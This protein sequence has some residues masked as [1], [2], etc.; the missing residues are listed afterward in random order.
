[1]R[2]LL[3]RLSQ[4]RVIDLAQ[5]WHVGMPHWPSHPPFLYSLTKLHGETVLEGGASSAADAI[6]LGTHTGTHI[7]ALCHFSCL[8]KL[9]GGDEAARVQSYAGGLQRHSVDTIA[10][11]L[12]RGVL[13]DIPGFMGVEVL[14]QDFE[15]TAQHLE[16]AS[17]AQNVEVRAGDV[18]LLR[19]GWARHYGDPTLFLN[20]LVLPGPA[21]EGAR[22]LSSRGVFAVGSDTVAFERT[23][24]AKM[25][26]HA[27]LLV[28]SGI[29]II[30]VLNLEQLAAEKVYEFLFVGSPLKIRGATGSPLRPF[31]V[32]L[33][34]LA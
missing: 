3:E 33:G 16:R 19:T 26:V 29:H 11:M 9:R 23:P 32:V 10:P 2:E 8:G 27:H 34:R 25:E 22:W 24:S 31:A 21:L 15:I 14:P 30:E 18:V 7:D 28:E 20:G 1:M 5:P 13:L 12:R 6:A 4:S 17:H